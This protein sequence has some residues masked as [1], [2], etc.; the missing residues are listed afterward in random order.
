MFLC[1]VTQK[2]IYFSSR[3]N[4][5]HKIRLRK[6]MLLNRV[7]PLYRKKIVTCLELRRLNEKFKVECSRQNYRKNVNKNTEIFW[8]RKRIRL[9]YLA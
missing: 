9:R 7:L 3:Y 5:T 4:I 2:I 1:V 6:S 8:S